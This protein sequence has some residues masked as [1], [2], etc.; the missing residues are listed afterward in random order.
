MFI[1]ILYRS[2]FNSESESLLVE[3]WPKVVAM[4]DHS[5]AQDKE[6]GFFPRNNGSTPDQSFDQWKTQGISA[7]SGGLWIGALEA[8][9]AM[10]RVLTAKKS[11]EN[12]EVPELRSESTAYEASAKRYEE[13]ATKCRALYLSKLWNGQYIEYDETSSAHSKSVMAAQLV[14][15]WYARSCA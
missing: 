13:M 9:A 14:G 3:A 10:A 8:A 1:L 4:L 7:Y 11:R 6:E 2:Y 15:D 12:D 5:M